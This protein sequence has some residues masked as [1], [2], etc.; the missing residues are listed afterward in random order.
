M[1][2]GRARSSEDLGYLPDNTGDN[3]SDLNHKFGELTGIYWVW[4][5]D[6]DSD[7]IGVCH[8]RRFFTDDKG[9]LMEAVDF[10]NAISDHGVLISQCIPCE[11]TYRENYAREHQAKDIDALEYGIQT[12]CPN[13]LPEFYE[14]MNGHKRYFGNIFVMH[15][16]DYMDYCAWLFDVLVTAGEKIDVTGYDEYHARIYG[17]LSEILVYVWALHNNKNIH[18]GHLMMTGEKAES[19]ELKDALTLL[20]KNRQIAE[21][22]KMFEEVTKVR[23]DV[24]MKASDL[25][26]DLNDIW[27]IILICD[28]EMKEGKSELLDYST[29]INVLLKLLRDKKR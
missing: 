22:K 26:G 8:Y 20:I 19:L 25:F 18:E 16:Q 3:I 9:R 12:A 7:I 11:L 10:E 1:Q 24:L 4:K 6:M 23:P 27:E 13:Y 2:V 17:F 28:K 14:A 29:D 21:A 15:R 5:N